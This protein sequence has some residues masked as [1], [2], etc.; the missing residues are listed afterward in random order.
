MKTLLAILTALP[1]ALAY[2][3]FAERPARRLNRRAGELRQ[4]YSKEPK[5]AYLD[6]AIAL[7]EEAA[8]RVQKGSPN[9]AVYLTNLGRALS[10]RFRAT[11]R[12]ED[13]DRAVA[14]LQEAVDG[15]PTNSPDR[16]SRVEACNRAIRDRDGAGRS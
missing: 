7:M 6:E 3:L 13:I 14:R 15:T 1:R 11:L 12:R 16:A 8:N 4:K 2:E 10:T 9:R 5:L